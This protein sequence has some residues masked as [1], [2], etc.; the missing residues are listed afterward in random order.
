MNLHSR[1][2]LCYSFQQRRFFYL[3]DCA[4]RQTPTEPHTLPPTRR[5]WARIRNPYFSLCHPTLPFHLLCFFLPKLRSII[6]NYND[7]SCGAN[8][9]LLVWFCQNERRGGTDFVC[10]HDPND[11][12]PYTCPLCACCG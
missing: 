10:L 4:F 3:Y 11:S 2:S 7:F 8:P 6:T 9:L 12:L 1:F 5:H